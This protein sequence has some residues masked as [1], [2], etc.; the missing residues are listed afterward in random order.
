MGEIVDGKELE[1]RKSLNKKIIIFAVVAIFIIGLIGSG[2]SGQSNS[3]ASSSNASTQ[4]TAKQEKWDAN[5]ELFGQT[6]DS[7]WDEIEAK[8][9]SIKILSIKGAE[10]SNEESTRHTSTTQSWR[11]TKASLDESAK[12]VTITVTS[13]DDFVDKYGESAKK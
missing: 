7:A 8:G 13:N 1:K 4:S 3:S 5:S 10:L 12:T 11:V 6:V 2:M 9:Y